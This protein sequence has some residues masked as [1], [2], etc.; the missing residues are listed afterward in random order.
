MRVLLLDRVE[1]IVEKEEIACFEQFILLRQCFQKSS[2][3]DASKYVYKC[4]K[5]PFNVV[6]YQSILKIKH[7]KSEL[8][9]HLYIVWPIHK[10]EHILTNF[11]QGPMD[12]FCVH[13]PVHLAL[14]HLLTLIFQQQIIKLLMHCSCK[15]IFN[16]Q[17]STNQDF[18]CF[19]LQIKTNC[20]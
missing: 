10:Y 2:S 11:W 4:E 14:S 8:F 7:L 12:M 18:Q 17:Y 16:F 15:T 13:Y 20:I 5:R 19:K 6:S 1:N 3:E 9:F